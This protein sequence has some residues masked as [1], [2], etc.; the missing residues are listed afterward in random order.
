MEVSL[1]PPLGLGVAN[2]SRHSYGEDD[3][4][5]VMRVFWDLFDGVGEA[6]NDRVGLGFANVFGIISNRAILLYDV[7]QVVANGLVSLTDLGLLYQINNLSVPSLAL[8][9]GGVPI[10]VFRRNQVP[11]FVWEI[12]MG[13]NDPATRQLANTFI[14]EVLDSNGNSLFRTLKMVPPQVVIVQNLPN[15]KAKMSWTPGAAEW[16]AVPVPNDNVYQVV[17]TLA[18]SAGA[19]N[20]GGFVFGIV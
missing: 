10:A 18:T 15:A 12:P 9:I 13:E 19:Y 16:N 2:S 8:E 20:S 6:N 5:A 17:I 4:N 1:L 14:V 11:T 7:R 3:E